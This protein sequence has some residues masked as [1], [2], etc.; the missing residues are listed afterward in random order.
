MDAK[1]NEVKYT[2]GLKYLLS[3]TGE[4]IVVGIGKATEINIVIPEMYNN[5]PVTAIAKFAFQ[6]CKKIEN[7]TIPDSVTSIDSFAFYGCKSLI[8]VTIPDS[9]TNVGECAFGKCKKLSDLLVSQ[10]FISKILDEK[11]FSD[12]QTFYDIK[13]KIYKKNQD[14][15]NDFSSSK[16]QAIE[17]SLKKVP[18]KSKIHTLFFELLISGVAT[19]LTTLI[20]SEFTIYI[21]LALCTIFL[22]SLFL[23]AAYSIRRKIILN[24][25]RNKFI[26]TYNHQEKMNNRNLVITKEKTQPRDSSSVAVK[27]K[28]IE[29]KMLYEEGL[30]TEA[31]YN[32]KRKS[33]INEL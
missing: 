9:V 24:N 3:K 19:I 14:T 21:F 22:C 18:S 12:P 13:L 10:L 32:E 2:E 6:N 8:S 20:E 4:Y 11:K 5:K 17:S 33:Y 23:L 27:N 7:I 26:N 16:L 28:L 29:L 1:L 15:K 25:I 31:D 30:I